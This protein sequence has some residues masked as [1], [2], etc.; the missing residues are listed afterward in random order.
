M[1]QVSSYSITP[2]RVMRATSS[3]RNPFGARQRKFIKKL[4]DLGT[5]VEQDHNL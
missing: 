2:S 5:L 3:F 4:N 1:I